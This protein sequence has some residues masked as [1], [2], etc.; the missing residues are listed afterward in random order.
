MP[1][2]D[3]L[4]RAAFARIEFPI[5][6]V[7]VSGAIREH[8]HKYPHAPGAALE[9]LGRELYEIRMRAQF[10][11]SFKGYPN[12]W[13]GSL[14]Q[15]RS[16]YEAE[17]TEDLVIPTIGTI[18][19]TCVRWTQTAAPKRARSGES[20]EFVFKEDLEQAFLVTSLV[21]TSRNT[22][23][24]DTRDLSA[25]VQKLRDAGPG[26]FPTEAER[27]FQLSIFDQIQQASNDI[28]GLLDSV[29]ESSNLLLA[30]VEQMKRILDN[31]DRQAKAL[32]NAENATLLA[33][34]LSVWDAVIGVEK[35]LLGKNGGIQQY[36][37][38]RQMSVS[39]LSKT[40]YSGD[41][42]HAVELMQINPIRDPFA[43]PAQT[44][45]RYYPQA[46]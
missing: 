19:A 21:T 23:S 38:I 12:L 25:E 10:H 41:G 37:L 5:E 33:A 18:R 2:F 35:D 28:L 22:F 29:D 14:A 36:T 20:V 30:K 34:F 4:Q 46:A 3:R 26:A 42:T 1:A 9:K 11:D 32:G 8:E 16:L 24:E 44:T 40:L 43:I 27:S 39:E 13:P 45:V 7:T 15:L 17:T 31:A 6:E